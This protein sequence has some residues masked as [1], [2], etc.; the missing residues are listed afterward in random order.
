MT[1]HARVPRVT[2]PVAESIE[3]R[4][5]LARPSVGV[6][7]WPGVVVLHDAVGLT[8]VTQLHA[9]RLATAGYLALAPDLYTRGGLVKC[10]A[11]TFRSMMA[12]QGQAYADIRASH[13]W[14]QQRDDCTKRIGVIG[15]CMGGGFALMTAT[16]GFDAS[17]ANYAS[18]PNFPE[19][20]RACPIVASYGAND[21]RLRGA[22]DRLRSA[23]SQLD[24][25]NDVKTYPGVAHSFLDRYN[26]GPL[27]P[28]VRMAGFGYDHASAEDAWART[29]RFF[30]QHLN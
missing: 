9:D 20:T 23:L 14:L 22:G 7:P 1:Y 16:R 13:D 18:V 29:L 26:L 2:V 8:Q 24:V 25:A 3:L 28:L 4:A 19:L 6:G 5:Y 10:L 21:R 11:A 30:A 15:F 17:A 12:G 27:T